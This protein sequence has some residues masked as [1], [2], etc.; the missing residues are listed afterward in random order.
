LPAFR[1]PGAIAIGE[2]GAGYPL[3]WSVPTWLPATIATGRDPSGSVP[4]AGDLAEF[5]DQVRA[6]DT[7]GRTF[8]PTN[9]GGY[10]RSQDPWLEGC[11]ERSERML[12]VLRLRRTWREFRTLPRTAVD[13][14]TGG[15]LIPGNLLVADGWLTGVLDVGGM[16]PA[17]PAIDLRLI[18]LRTV[19]G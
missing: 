6:I 7:A 4:F 10:L 17:D 14:M 13:V 16:A 12:D 2:P 11:F 19:A 9:R 8:D 18:R 3:L 1:T 15:D 5:V